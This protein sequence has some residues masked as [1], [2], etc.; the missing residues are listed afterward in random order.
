MRKRRITIDNV[1]DYHVRDF[2]EVLGNRDYSSYMTSPQTEW[3]GGVE[4][5]I[6]T[7]IFFSDVELIYKEARRFIGGARNAYSRYNS[8]LRRHGI[9]RRGTSGSE[10]RDTDRKKFETY[11]ESHKTRTI[12]N[13]RHAISELCTLWDNLGEILWNYYGLYT[14]VNF[15][16]A[17][18]PSLLDHLKDRGELFGFFSRVGIMRNRHGKICLQED[19][20]L[21]SL[22]VWRNTARH[23]FTGVSRVYGLEFSTLW[24]RYIE[25]DDMD[26]RRR[27]KIMTSDEWVDLTARAYHH[28]VICYNS[29]LGAIKSEK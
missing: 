17:R 23:G 2:R 29:L 19:G 15:R 21:H 25:F 1:L 24:E 9:K 13:C 3:E 7:H 11:V 18:F 27:I 8:A 6:V 5:E 22:L 10:V 16:D 14:E 12:M 28:F 4:S 26:G 20:T